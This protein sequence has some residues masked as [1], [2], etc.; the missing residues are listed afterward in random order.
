VS[1]EKESKDKTAEDSEIVAKLGTINSIAPVKLLIK[2]TATLLRT[3]LLVGNGH[4][5]FI[6]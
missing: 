4:G 6:T 3:M 2:Y 5:L 1:P